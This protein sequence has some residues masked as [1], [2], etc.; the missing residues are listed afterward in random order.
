MLLNGS[1]LREGS[2]MRFLS[3]CLILLILLCL[4]LQAQ[5][6]DYVRE[7]KLMRYE[8]ETY[9][10]HIKTV[11]L[12]V[13]GHEHSYPMIE[14]GAEQQLELRFDDLEGGY[15][16]Y[17]YTLIHC[18]AEWQPSDID[19]FDY[20][21]GFLDD[22]IDDFDHSFNTHQEYTHYRL[23][24]PNNELSV[25][26]SGNYLLKVYESG[27]EDHP[28]LTRRLMIVDPR[29]EISP[30]V[31]HPVAQ[32][33]F[34]SHQQLSF[35]VAYGGLNVLNPYT[36][37]KVV[38]L[39]NGR[40]DTALR[41]LRPIFVLEGTARYDHSDQGLFRAGQ[42]YRFFSTRTLFETAPRVANISLEPDWTATLTPDLVRDRESYRRWRDINGSFVIGLYDSHIDDVDAEYLKVNFILEMD[43]PIEEGNIYIFGGL[44][45]W[46]IRREAQLKYNYESRRYEGSLYLKQGYYNYIYALRRDGQSAIDEQALEG[47]FHL[48]ENDY[49]ILLYY[50]NPGEQYDQ[51]I[52][53]SA[54]NSG[55]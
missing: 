39:Q 20:I 47:S 10:P 21:V 55:Y 26:K 41:D 25:N 11:Q 6:P 28:I 34:L 48:A 15:K 23:R 37:L 50:R 45:D 27:D 35:K 22:R 24:F 49:H 52:G 32:R 42:E 12:I 53:V 9:F 4:C 1:I 8:N 29:V 54:T 18:D 16:D 14:L 33:F 46:Q 44:T 2:S 3:L 43:E 51:L 13:P 5:E 38:I 36:D 7:E 40:W 17:Q 19:P 31:G 30:L